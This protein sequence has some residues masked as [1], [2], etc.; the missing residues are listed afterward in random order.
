M[1]II[2]ILRKN[3][4][5][6]VRKIAIGELDKTKLSNKFQSHNLSDD[7]I[8]NVKCHENGEFD[9]RGKKGEYRIITEDGTMLLNFTGDSNYI[10]GNI[11]KDCR[12]LFPRN[13]ECDYIHPCKHKQ[14]KIS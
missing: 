8:V 11:E 6:F 2:K 7:V 5:I 13:N 9:L 4:E 12:F 3:K 10:C 1:N 14:I